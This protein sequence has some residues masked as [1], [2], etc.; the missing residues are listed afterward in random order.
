[1]LALMPVLPLAACGGEGSDQKG[2]DGDGGESANVDLSKYPAD[3]GSWSARNL[4]DYFTEAGVFDGSGGCESSI[5]TH[6]D[7]AGGGM[8]FNEIGNYYDE[9]GLI[10]I[11]FFTFDD[12]LPDTPSETVEAAKTYAREHKSMGEEQGMFETIIDHM[13]G[14][15]AVSYSHT[16][17]EDM[18][19]R[20]DAAWAQLVK[21]TGAQVDF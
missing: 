6:E 10:T 5:D 15:V 17:D 1:M 20:M 8:P 3:L 7:L 16:S 19:N 21:A 13:V 14:N 11:M 12:T 18:Y 4:I 2:G 9:A